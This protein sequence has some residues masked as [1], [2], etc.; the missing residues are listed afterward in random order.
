MGLAAAETWRGGVGS[1]SVRE[2]QRGFREKERTEKGA[3]A[4]EFEVSFSLTLIHIF[5][6]LFSFFGLLYIAHQ[7]VL[8][9]TC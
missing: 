6:T 4:G 3:S 5:L 8:D 7:F 1:F 9:H 2:I